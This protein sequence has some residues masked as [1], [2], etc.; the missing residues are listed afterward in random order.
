MVKNKKRKLR[1]APKVFLILVIIAFTLYSVHALNMA[2]QQRLNLT[3]RLNHIES[4]IEILSNRAVILKE[5]MEKIEYETK[6]SEVVDALFSNYFIG[7]GSSSEITASGYKISDFDVN[8]L[9]WYTFQN[10]VVVAT[11]N[12]T[13]LSKY[14]YGGY[15]SHELFEKI[16]LIIEDVV[17][18]AIV[19]DVCGACYGISN[20]TKQRYDIF[21]TGPTIGLIA[22]YV[23]VDAIESEIKHDE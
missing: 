12:T 6:N 14:L 22:G 10:K 4:K 23:I 8:E 3:N 11:A 16:H 7:D 2:K 17:Y 9:G 1:R 5:I 15:R 20:E 19:L 18:P 21:T 13:R